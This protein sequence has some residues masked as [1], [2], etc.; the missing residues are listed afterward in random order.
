VKTEIVCGEYVRWKGN[1]LGCAGGSEYV[2]L[3]DIE[4]ETAVL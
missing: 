3:P 2:F 1:W 4:T